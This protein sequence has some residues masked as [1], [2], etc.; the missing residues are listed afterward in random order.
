M[1]ILLS[2]LA[3][4]HA[5]GLRFAEQ[6]ITGKIQ[7]PEIQILITKQNLTPKYELEL[8]ESFLPRIVE[9]VEQKP[10]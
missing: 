4:A 8:R 5:A 2:L 3:P 1:L 9:A 10:F 6:K 7:K